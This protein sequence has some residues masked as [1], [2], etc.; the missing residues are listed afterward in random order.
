VWVN[1][2]YKKCTVNITW[3]SETECVY[4]AV[5]TEYLNYIGSFL[6]IRWFKL[7][8]SFHECFVRIRRSVN[9]GYKNTFISFV[10]VKADCSDR[11]TSQSV[12][13]DV[14]VVCGPQRT[15]VGRV[16]RRPQYL[17]VP[18]RLSNTGALTPHLGAINLVSQR[19][20]E[21]RVSLRG[22][23]TC[24]H[25]IRAGEPRRNHS[26]LTTSGPRLAG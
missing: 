18:W 6:R 1:Q 7:L 25:L 13:C 14:C 23:V 20:A 10:T 26:L 17:C 2:L 11:C 8:V 19:R 12:A 4:C 3:S 15:A 22:G 16:M 5:Q 21:A 24:W 9:I